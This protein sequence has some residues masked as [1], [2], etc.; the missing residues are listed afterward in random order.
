MS[1]SLV[2]SSEITSSRPSAGTSK[3]SLGSICSSSLWLNHKLA[4]FWNL[5]RW[6]NNELCNRDFLMSQYMENIGGH[7]RKF[8]ITFMHSRVRTREV[9]IPGSIHT[10]MV[11]VFKDRYCKNFKRVLGCIACNDITHVDANWTWRE[12]VIP[13]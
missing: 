2:V 3:F 13:Y 11:D 6:T 5:W 12:I 4:C 8:T 1:E 9:C 10:A 7:N